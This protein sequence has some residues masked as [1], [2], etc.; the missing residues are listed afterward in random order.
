MSAGFK[1]DDTLFW[2][3][4]GAIEAYLEALAPLA[5]SHLGKDHPITEFFHGEQA[6]FFT[7]VV[8][9]L[10]PLAADAATC[11]RLLRLFD[12]ATEQLLGAGS[13]TESGK[14]WVRE[15]IG[16]LRARLSR[17]SASGA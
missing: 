16:D 9:D 12:L 13:F 1:L 11:G 4:N 17:A 2:G 14:L 5:E 3:T 6:M 8:V 7:G 10:S 15:V